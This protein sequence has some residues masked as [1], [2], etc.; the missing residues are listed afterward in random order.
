MNTE[1]FIAG[2]L[3]FSRD[4]KPMKVMTRI[5][6]FSVA[7]SI[8]VMIV[9]A[10]V[11]AGFK[12]Q[13][14]EKISGFNSH[15]RIAN[16]DSNYSFDTPP[17]RND[18]GFYSSISA[19]PEV[20]HIQQ[21]AYKGGII[22][23]SSDIQGIVLKGAGTDFDWSFFEQYMVDGKIFSVDTPSASDSVII[24]ESLS[25]LLNL[26]TGDSFE[27]YFIQEPVRVRRF[28]ISGLYNTYFEEMDRTYVIC[29]IRH[30]RRLNRW[31][32]RQ[33]SGMEIMLHNPDDMDR[34]YRKID[35]IAGYLTFDDG[36][37]L[38]VTTLRNAFPEIFNWLAILDMNVIIILII[39]AVVAGFNMISGLL[40]MLL[41]KI[42]M[43]GILKSM[44]MTDF[45]IRKIFLY[46]SSMIAL[47][48]LLYGNIL[49]LSLC[50]LQQRFGIIHID[51]QNYFFSTAPVNI[52]WL[53]VILL[54]VCSFAF[55]SLTQIIPTM[56]I[57]RISPDKTMR[58]E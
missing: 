42:S 30:I 23:A 22:R 44:G 17:I 55:I 21:Y 38:E 34:A 10:S 58:K 20:K 3:S 46:R 57:A 15:L 11:L 4:N 47:R 24:S 29:D 53:N 6:V 18:Y 49:G 7:L 41:E 16:L 5:A 13:L 40:I 31:D 52:N 56:L 19:L 37:R 33:I 25:R 2:K 27:M 45:S 54:N 48:G 14:K 50:I 1:L 35:D 12:I 28:T 9:A 8:A 26:K 36:S 51:P 32:D 39:M 43:I